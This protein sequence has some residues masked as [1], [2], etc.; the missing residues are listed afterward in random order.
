M[1]GSK[2]RSKAPNEKPMCIIATVVLC[3]LLRDALLLFEPRITNTPLTPSLCCFC[4][5]LQEF[6]GLLD[7]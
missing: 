7:Y 1:S 4:C 6:P 3:C 2:D 5:G